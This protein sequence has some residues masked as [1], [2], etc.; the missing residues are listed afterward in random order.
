MKSAKWEEK[1]KFCLFVL[2]QS[3]LF[4]LLTNF[5]MDESKVGSSNTPGWKRWYH[6]IT[7]QIGIPPPIPYA[8]HVL[9]GSCFFFL[10]LCNW[11]V[12]FNSEIK[13]L[14][15]WAMIYPYL[16]HSRRLQV[17]Q[18]I[19]CLVVWIVL[20]SYCSFSLTNI[21]AYRK[22]KVLQNLGPNQV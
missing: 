2:V 21:D 4:I 18:I 17:A 11:L 5:F 3:F 14:F 6:K 1:V 7:K 10:K 13:L 12:L 19:R 15:I 9:V 8:P 20:I 16:L 22:W